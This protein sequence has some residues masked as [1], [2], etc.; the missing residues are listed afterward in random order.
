MKTFWFSIPSNI[1]TSKRINEVI[2]LQKQIKEIRNNDLK[3]IKNRIN[4]R[5]L[6]SSSYKNR[7][8]CRIRFNANFNNFRSKKITI[9][10]SAN[11]SFNAAKTYYNV[12]N[13][14]IDGIEF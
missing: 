3:K 5:K 8:L 6:S 1:Q 13:F 11:Q 9:K 2:S 7:Y 12:S 10:K 14:D 4:S